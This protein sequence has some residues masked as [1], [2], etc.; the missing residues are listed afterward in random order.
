MNK[1]K[2]WKN[3]FSFNYK[4][5]AGAKSYIAVTTLMAVVLMATAILISVFA[6]KPEESEK[7][8]EAVS[9]CNVE[10]AYVLDLAG[11]GE[12]KFDEW[13][14][15]LSDMY[16][17]DFSF[18]QVS[19]MTIEELQTKAAQE[20]S[21]HAIG[22]VIEKEEKNISVTAVVPSTSESLSLMDGQE[23]ADLVASAVEQA[24]VE[25]SGLSEL[26]FS[27]INK[28]VVVSVADAGVE[29]NVVV[30]LVKYLAPAFFGLI[31]YFL[32]LL[33]G[34]KIC[35]GVSVEKT[36]KLVETLLT[37]LHPYALLAGSNGVTTVFHLGC[38]TVCGYTDRWNVGG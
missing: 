3:V 13:I 29:N 12:L 11:M 15:E 35:Q 34:Q 21:G 32:L 28:Q 4:Q 31:L 27:Q 7:N 6:A 17:L 33:Y 2:G 36:S 8:V 22:V 14:P 23:I 10:T 26:Q 18:V 19:D 25:Q 9:F 37:S 20:P 1:F 38:C 30:Y 5:S 16:Y 24:R